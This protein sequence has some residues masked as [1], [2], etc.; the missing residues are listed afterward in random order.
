M[1]IYRLS[2]GL[3]AITVAI[4]GFLVFRS[5]PATTV[6]PESSQ[7]L[8]QLTN[9][10]EAGPAKVGQE[11]DRLASSSRPHETSSK[12]DEVIRLSQSPD[13]SQK[14]LAYELIRA[15]VKARKDDLYVAE[16]AADGGKASLSSSSEVCGDIDPG[17]IASRRQLLSVA[18]QAGV[19][20]A[21][22][23][24]ADEGATGEGYSRDADITS[25][26]Q[27]RFA[28]EMKQAIEAGAASGDWWSLATL[29]GSRE[30]SARTAEDYEKAIEGL[31]EAN[32][33]YRKE[34]GHDMK[35]YQENRGRMTYFGNQA[36][37]STN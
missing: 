3:L 29:A 21:A 20:H 9:A 7:G 25:A 15:C 24:L 31:D 36:K 16:R 12:R 11:P 4:A 14:L 18:A 30:S 5:K 19:H 8:M 27:Q 23:Y 35:S 22:G 13:P 34:T 37:T 17:Q 10:G 6:E 26:D 32:T 28:N 1:K 2:I 33:A